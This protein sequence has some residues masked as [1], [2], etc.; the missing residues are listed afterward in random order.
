MRPSST[1]NNPQKMAAAPDS[2]FKELSLQGK[3]ISFPVDPSLP[4]PPPNMRKLYPAIQPYQSGHLAV[5]D[6]HEIYYEQCGKFYSR[7]EKEK[8]T[9]QKKTT[10]IFFPEIFFFLVCAW[11][12]RIF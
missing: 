8:K 5:G 12:L 6:G 7:F 2:Q 11:C 4:P 3:M 10:K 9:S 1:N